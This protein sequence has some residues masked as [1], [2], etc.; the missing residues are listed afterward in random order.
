MGLEERIEKLEAELLAEKR[1]NVL[2]LGVVAS[3]V[4]ALDSVN[5]PQMAQVLAKHAL[6]AVE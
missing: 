1:K 4:S 5:M 2:L 6:K 3:M